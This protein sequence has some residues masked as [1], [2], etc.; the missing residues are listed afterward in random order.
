[1]TIVDEL[2]ALLSPTIADAKNSEVR[3]QEL[4]SG[5]GNTA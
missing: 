5:I 2:H 1:M 3:G 4:V